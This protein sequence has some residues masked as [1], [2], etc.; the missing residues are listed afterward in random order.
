[1]S[2]MHPLPPSIESRPGPIQRLRF[3]VQDVTL[4]GGMH[5]HES[6]RHSHGWRTIQM[7]HVAGKD[8]NISHL[9]S[10]GT[11]QGRMLVQLGELLPSMH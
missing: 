1:M 3:S 10:I 9:P 8:A 7:Y 5:V 6:S 2:W 4:D 11:S